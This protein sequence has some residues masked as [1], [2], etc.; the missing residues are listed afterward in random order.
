MVTGIML[1]VASEKK[2]LYPIKECVL[3]INITLYKHFFETLYTVG[4]SL[5]LEIKQ[6][7]VKLDFSEVFGLFTI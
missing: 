3:G 7:F 1:G 2:E 4:R 6:H 5:V